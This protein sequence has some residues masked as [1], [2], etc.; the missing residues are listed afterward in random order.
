MIIMFNVKTILRGQS[1]F[2]FELD[3]STAVPWKF[4]IGCNRSNNSLCFC[5]GIAVPITTM[6]AKISTEAKMGRTISLAGRNTIS[7]SYL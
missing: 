1:K 6:Q 4:I 3:T 7:K 5:L 2:P